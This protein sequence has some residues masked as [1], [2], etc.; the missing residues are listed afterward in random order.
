VLVV[1]VVVLVVLVVVIVV[2]VVVVVVVVTVV[3]VTLILLSPNRHS[4]VLQY[5][6]VHT[7]HGLSAALLCCWPQ[8]VT[9]TK[10]YQVGSNIIFHRAKRTDGGT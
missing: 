6:H 3:A 1:L 10:I 9:F 4:T 8:L 2:L 7:Q 5:S